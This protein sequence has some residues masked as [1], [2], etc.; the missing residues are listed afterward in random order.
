M[1]TTEIL[2]NDFSRQWEVVGPAVLGAVERVGTSGRYILGE[3]VE[4]FEKA[5]AKLCGVEFAAGAGNGM[6]AIEIAL[7]CLGL[8]SGDQVL[9]TPLSAFATTLAIVRAG[10]IPVFVDV[11]ALGG[12]DLAQCRTVLEQNP[13]IRFL[14]PVHLYGVPLDLVELKRL[15]EDFGLAVVED[16]AQAIGATYGTDQVGSVGQMSAVSLYP[17]KNLGALGDAGAV[18]TN[19]AELARRA[20]VL[21]NYG[22]SSVYVHA[23]LGSNSRLDEL[24]A[25][26]LHSALLPHFRQ[27]TDTRRETARTYLQRIDN[28]AIQTV[29]LNSA[30]NAA[31]HLFPVIV[32]PRH[33]DAFRSHLDACHIA[34][35]IHYPRLI[36][37]QAAL[38]NVPGVRVFFDPAHALRF[39]R[40]EVSLPIHPFLTKDDV[41]AV[42]TACNNWRV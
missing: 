26:I 32:A 19:D 23:E 36:P 4:T 9:T 5:F 33:R 42:I 15:R 38:N 6:D 11:D 7:R 17:T 27:W 29:S 30:A 25:A 22:Q 35:G 18:S 13:S 28:P 31:W 16:C 3:E 14:V 41:A 12:L 40:G 34:T 1:A 24:Q 37:E 20:M 21:R 10:G 39:V 8:R 2:Q